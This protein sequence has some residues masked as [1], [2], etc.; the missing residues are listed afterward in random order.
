MIYNKEYFK[1][2]LPKRPEDSNKGTFGHVLNIAGSRFYTGA[3]YFSSISAL[4][5]GCGR[6]TLASEAAACKA[7]ASLCPDIILMPLD[8][9][10]KEVFNK[11]QVISIGCG[12]STE[13]DA[14]R[15]FKR[16]LKFLEN[17]DIPVVI[18]ADGLNILAKI[19]V[20][21][22]KNVI[23]T[24]HPGEMTRLMGV[25]I[26]DILEQPEFWVK[27]C[28]EKFNCTTVLK[29][30]KT[31][32]ADNSG[33]FY[34]NN[35]GNSA[36]SHGGSGDVLTG[37]ISGFLAQGLNLFEASCLAVY[38]HGKTAEIA[39]EELTEYCTLASDLINYIP[40]AMF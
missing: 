40:K 15:L 23:L 4:R 35:S 26:Y 19:K 33:N 5:V 29:L 20:R 27:K 16:V 34:E 22:P 21:L 11:F 6:V 32:V 31:L 2:L 14:V 13:K 8:K 37:M 18:D 38:L 39:S 36:L 10:K 30:H 3:A 7:A 1:N 28:C 25:D 12:L 24:P 17:F 9:L